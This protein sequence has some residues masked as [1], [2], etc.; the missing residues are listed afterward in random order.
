MEGTIIWFQYF[1]Q[2]KAF[3]AALISTE[4]TVI[5]RHRLL[6]FIMEQLMQSEESRVALNP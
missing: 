5:F 2:R 4:S 1:E 3:F 6:D